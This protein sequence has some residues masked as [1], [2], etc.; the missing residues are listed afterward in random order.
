[1]SGVHKMDSEAVDEAA[2]L[3]EGGLT[4]VQIGRRY[5]ISKQGL[6]KRLRGKIVM[7]PKAGFRHGKGRIDRRAGRLMRNAIKK[8]LITRQVV[9]A[10][11]G[12][13]AV[14]GHHDDY[15]K[16][17]EVRWLCRPCHYAWHAANFAVPFHESKYENAPPAGEVA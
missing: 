13:K 10:G 15:N 5:G 2:R 12:G 14:E 8:G 7:R 11:C 16:P 6:W 4:L 1:M 3:Y 9:C 17:L